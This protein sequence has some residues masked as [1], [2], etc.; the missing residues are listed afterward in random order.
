VTIQYLPLGGGPHGAEI[1][2]RDRFRKF[3]KKKNIFLKDIFKKTHGLFIRLQVKSVN[4]T[5]IVS[6]GHSL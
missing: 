2:I 4:Q 1:C 6:F 5:G 3:K